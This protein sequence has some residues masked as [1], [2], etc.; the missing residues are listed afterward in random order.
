MKLRNKLSYIAL[1]GLLMLIGMLAS[2]VF[3]PSLFAKPEYIHEIFCDRLTVVDG[4]NL[5][6]EGGGSIMLRD[7]GGIFVLGEKEL[8][9]PTRRAALGVDEHGNGVVGVFDGILPK[10]LLTVGEDGSGNVR[11]WGVDGQ[12]KVLIGAA[13]HGGLVGVLG[14]NERSATAMLSVTEHG[15]RVSVGGKGEGQAVMRINEYGNGAVSTWD[16]NGYRQ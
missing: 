13:E 8:P 4:G 11:V 2:N 15:G 5:T 10:V 9:V 14:K 6:L 1:G 16:K 12:Q 7:G 3:M